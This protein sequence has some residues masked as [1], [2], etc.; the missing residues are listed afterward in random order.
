MGQ[1][2][3]AL[4]SDQKFAADRWFRIEYID[5]KTTCAPHFSSHQASRPAAEDSE[6]R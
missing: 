5:P 4:A 3:A 2:E 6:V 1:V